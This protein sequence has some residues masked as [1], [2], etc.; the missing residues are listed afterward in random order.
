MA[1]GL[2]SLGRSCRQRSCDL[3]RADSLATEWLGEIL[4]VEAGAI[5]GRIERM[6]TWNGRDELTELQRSLGGYL[7]TRHRDAVRVID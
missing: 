2:E 1:Q 4:S 6:A 3:V 5:A 7:S